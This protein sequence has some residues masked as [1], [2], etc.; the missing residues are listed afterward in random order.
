MRYLYFALILITGCTSHAKEPR[1][2]ETVCTPYFKLFQG[3]E[4]PSRFIAQAHQESL[5]N[6]LAK[7]PV[8]AVGLM[9]IM[10]FNFDWF[11]DSICRHLGKARPNN[12]WWSAKC[13]MAY[14]D[15]FTV[16]LFNDYCKN[17][18]VDEQRYNGGYHI[19]WELNQGSL[20]FDKAKNICGTRLS[21]GRKRSKASCRE[22]Y[23][24]PKKISDR[25]KQYAEL[26][27][28]QC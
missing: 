2:I 18:E 19:I 7:S 26:G 6:P 5:C 1:E 4:N 23:D 12:A 24:Y 10:P 20:D 9:Q 22:N 28:I 3:S 27:G 13:G 17:K 16:D 25:Q 14:M 21:N 11:E 15:W 8:G